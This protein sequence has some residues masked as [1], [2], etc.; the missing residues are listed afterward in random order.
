VEIPDMHSV[1]EYRGRASKIKTWKVKTKI[2]PTEQLCRLSC[3]LKNQCRGSGSGSRILSE[4]GSGSVSI[5]L[6][7]KNSSLKD[8]Q[9]T[10]EAFSLQKR[11]SSTSKKEIY[12]LFVGNFFSSWIRIQGP[13]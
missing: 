13:N 8:V 9:A 3:E 7:D 4:S 5:V 10:G 6:L 1:S 2:I 11:T 12:Q